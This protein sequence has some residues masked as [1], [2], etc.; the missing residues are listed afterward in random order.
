V[1]KQ[2]AFSNIHNRSD[3][4]DD[5]LDSLTPADV[6]VLIKTCEELRVTS[7]FTRIFPTAATHK[8]LT[9]MKAEEEA[10]SYYDK[11]LDSFMSYCRDTS[12]LDGVQLVRNMTLVHFPDGFVSGR[13]VQL[14]GIRRRTGPRR[15]SVASTPAA[16]N[17]NDQ[18]RISLGKTTQELKALLWIPDPDP[19][20]HFIPDPDPNLHFIPDPDPNLHFI[21][22]PDSN[23][24][25][26]ADPDSNLHFIP[27]PDP[28]L[29][30]ITDP[31][32][33]VILKLDHVK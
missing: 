14:N 31:D 19:Y 12:F 22:D 7:E 5:I 9:L 1:A 25:L 11:L 10:V 28:N 23:L 13:R 8:Y 27:D 18:K 16:E 26:I 15:G 33:D 30:I 2:K 20:L 24:H 32:H 4:K 21:P 17:G 29:H 6:K 3:Y